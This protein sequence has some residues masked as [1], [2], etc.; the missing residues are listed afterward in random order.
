V[1]LLPYQKQWI[2]DN[3]RWKIGMF[4][5]QTGK[6][7]TSTLELCLS[8]VRAEAEGRRERW[9]ILSRGERQ[10]KE[11]MDEGVRKH[12]HAIGAAYRD[13]GKAFLPRV[14]SLEVLLPGGSRITALPAN[15]DTARGYSAN[16]FLDEFAFHQD[17]DKIWES[18][19]PVVSHGNKRL[20]ITSTPNGTGNRFHTIMTEG[21]GWSRH[22]VTIHDAIR[23]GLNRNVA[24]LK[25]MLNDDDSWAQEFELQW[26]DDSS[27][28]LSYDLI[29]T[30]VDENAG[31]PYDY[32]DRVCYLGVDIAV[33]N[34]LFVAVVLELLDDGCFWVREV[35]A[36]QKISF[37]Q[38]DAVV[39]DLVKRYRIAR[40]CVDQTGI[41]E[42]TVE[43][44]QSQYGQ[45][46]VNGV[47]FTPAAKLDMAMR[48][49][50]LFE[51]RRIRV[52]NDTDFIND[53]HKLTKVIGPTGVVRIIA[54]RDK[55]G[56]AD[57]AWA[58]FLATEASNELI[59]DPSYSRHSGRDL[60]YQRSTGSTAG[61]VAVNNEYDNW[62]C[63]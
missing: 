44:L 33:R 1:I 4:A 2:N 60:P 25:A 54:D 49:R 59:G 46:M 6:T 10:A 31:K 50:K 32:T 23:D 22:T 13:I 30:C 36:H 34:D 21:V 14:N 57:R 38:Q 58:L 39:A 47:M 12:L 15:P 45:R 52:P 9:V 16:V 27:A 26:V 29:N 35:A 17:S 18:L 11:A 53:L 19:F 41:G 48:A 62:G 40:I 28:W 55:S 61:P 56:H 37:K 51:T 5:R 8:C 20:I 42:R 3:S 24:D 43:E 63:V 7:F